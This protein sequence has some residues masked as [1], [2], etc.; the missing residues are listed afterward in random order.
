VLLL[1]RTVHI[2]G[3]PA[4]GLG[5]TDIATRGAT[6]GLFKEFVGR[7]RQHYVDTYGADSQQVKDCSNGYHSSRTL[8]SAFSRRCSRP[9]PTFPF[10]AA[11]SSTRTS[12][13]SRSTVRA[14]LP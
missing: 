8:L 14:L 13:T 6:G 7:V 3:L 5:A 1:E 2:G 10:C 4:N 11:A 9:S 12:A